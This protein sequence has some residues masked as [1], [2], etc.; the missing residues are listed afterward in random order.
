MDRFKPERNNQRRPLS[1]M[2][3]PGGG[4]SGQGG[5]AP[6]G[7]RWAQSNIAGDLFS[8][9]NV[10]PGSLTPMSTG[11][12]SAYFGQFNNSRSQ[13]QRLPLESE[14]R[15]SSMTIAD[16]SPRIAVKKVLLLYEHAQYHEASN[17]IDRLSVTT[18][19]IIL[20]E[21][22][23]DIFIEAMPHSLPIMESLYSKVFASEGS[24]GNL[25]ALKPYSVLM[26]IV[27]FFARD[28][29]NQQCRSGRP[30]EQFIQFLSDCKKILRAMVLGEPRLI[31]TLQQRAKAL[32]KAV[33][34]MGHHSLVGTTDESLLPLHDALKLEFRRVVDTYKEALQ[35][36]EELALSAKNS[37]KSV[38]HGPAP[39]AASHQRQLSLRV[40]EIQDR[41]IKNKSLL[42]VVEPTLD[43][44]CLDILLGILQ[45][46]I[47]LDK[48]TLFQ[49]TQ[50]RKEAGDT[51]N[52]DAI[53]APLLM[54]YSRAS[55]KV[56][57]IMREAA[58]EAGTCLDD[59]EDDS[60]D[61]SGYHSDSDSAI[62]TSGNSPY[63]T[64]RAR[65]NFLSRSV[66]SKQHLRP[67]LLGSS[68]SSSGR[69]LSTGSAPESSTGSAL[70][71]LDSGSCSLTTASDI[72]PHPYK[73]HLHHSTT[74]GAL[75]ASSNNT[76]TR[77]RHVKHKNQLQKHSSLASTSSIASDSCS[78]RSSGGSSSPENARYLTRDGQQLT[79]ESALG[80][81]TNDD[82]NVDTISILSGCVECVTLVSVPDN[83][84]ITQG[85]NH[86]CAIPSHAK[87]N[88]VV[89][90]LRAEIS[91]LRSNLRLANSTIAQLQTGSP[92]SQSSSAKD[93]DNKTSSSSLALTKM[94]APG[95]LE[96]RKTFLVREY[97]ALYAQGR[98]ET[99]DALDSLPDLIEADELKSKL[100]FSVIV[101]AFRAVQT[102]LAEIK[103][104]VSNLLQLES[105]N[106]TPTPDKEQ[107]NNGVVSKKDEMQQYQ[108]RLV[109]AL[110]E[111]LH[112]SQQKVDQS[113]C[114]EVVANQLWTTLYDYPC[115]KNC[116]P[117]LKYIRTSVNLAWG[118]SNL[119]P[120]C[121]LEYET[122]A[123]SR[124]MHVRFHNSDPAS[125]TIK[126]YLWPALV[127]GIP[128]P[129][130]HKGVVIT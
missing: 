123:F 81:L 72:H 57:E 3:W 26:H 9:S 44:H 113:R 28:D 90:S 49:F 25:K 47:D 18:F 43:N 55:K 97:G 125:E 23:I 1:R 21:L 69:S 68:V 101:L 96:E 67:S 110:S 80:T 95:S 119:N 12:M 121:L 51:S 100:L 74:G 52:V 16:I 29:T 70:S 88:D 10:S 24:T 15:V 130:V 45:R 129:C 63:V 116:Q 35:K 48:D 30:N 60:S 38:A 22:P 7:G 112:H 14:S 32:D 94:L 120:P 83:Q 86:R 41:L 19:R 127:E 85:I 106:E 92:I 99:M 102:S 118:L 34:G 46:R 108:K 17:F 107:L 58:T 20:R 98:V 64:P 42:N 31:K 87:T 59:F 62:M 82:R 66:R 53:V 109:Q 2:R 36:L 115:L 76:P 39:V 37:P 84:V 11:E 27:N 124:D 54:R 8:C 6:G 111:Y 117:L 71:S 33:E 79:K 122:K 105:G 103:D 56:L 73:T 4:P 128:G 78:S 61:L 126:T 77:P 40:E 50:L 75:L 65:Y 13:F 89:N 114:V 5:A 104:Q 91:Q 93:K